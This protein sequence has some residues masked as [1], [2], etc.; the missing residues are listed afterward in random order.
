MEPGE[1]LEAAAL[2]E[3]YEE[4][5]LSGLVVQSYLGSAE[6]ELRRRLERA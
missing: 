2:R 1:P 3:A 4:T 6:Y 5:G